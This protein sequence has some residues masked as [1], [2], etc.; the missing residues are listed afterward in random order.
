MQKD[1]FWEIDEVWWETLGQYIVDM[2][3]SK[4]V[5]AAYEELEL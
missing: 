3:N 4:I 2:M 1:C 5:L